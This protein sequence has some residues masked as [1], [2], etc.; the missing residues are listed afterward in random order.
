MGTLLKLIG[1][2]VALI[3][4]GLAYFSYTEDQV[5]SFCESIPSDATPQSISDAA[6]ASGMLPMGES[7]QSTSVVVV[8][9]LMPYFRFSCEVTFEA[10]HVTSR[11]VRSAD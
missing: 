3:V 5:T 4:L 8:N 1:F 7:A 10:G 9:H 6:H 2:F 11:E